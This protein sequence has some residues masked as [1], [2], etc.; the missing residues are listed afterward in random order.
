MDKTSNL[1][2]RIVLWIQN[3]TLTENNVCCRCMMTQGGEGRGKEH[4]RSPIGQVPEDFRRGHENN[5]YADARSGSLCYLFGF[6][7]HWGS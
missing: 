2:A 3:G 4:D 7:H 5:T 6:G 1:K